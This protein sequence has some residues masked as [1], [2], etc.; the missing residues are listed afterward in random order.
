LLVFFDGP[1]VEYYAPQYE[2]GKKPC[3]STCNG[4][5]HPDHQRKQVDEDIP[6]AI[7][8][9]PEL[10]KVGLSGGEIEARYGEDM[11]EIT[12][13]AESD[14]F[15]TDHKTAGFLTVYFNRRD[16]QIVG[17]EAAGYHAGEWIQLLSLA[18]QQ[19][20]TAAQVLETI[21]IYPTYSEIV[22]KACQKYV[23]EQ[24]A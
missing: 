6:W 24:E 8:T 13:Q 16:G 21:F 5:L 23:L 9:E 14:R 1:D 20:M 19:K 3:A 7:F 18:Y 17:A 22:R 4:R 10:A 11:V 12:V 2:P 15:I